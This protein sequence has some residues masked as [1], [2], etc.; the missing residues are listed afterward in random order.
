MKYDL[1]IRSGIHGCGNTLVRLILEYLV[2]KSKVIGTHRYIDNLEEP[3]DLTQYR[4]G[5]I[6]P[7][8]DFRSV[9]AN[10]I[11]KRKMQPTR[12][13]IG[14]VY[15]G[16][17]T[18]MYIEFHKFRTKYPYPKNV[19]LLSYLRFFDNYDY[20]LDRLQSFLDISVSNQQRN[21]IKEKFSMQANKK[22]I[23]ELKLKSWSD[24]D[25]TTLLHGNHIGTGEPDSW[26]TFF[27]PNLHEFITNLMN[28]EL[29]EYGWE[30]ERNKNGLV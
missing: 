24:I 29:V 10:T 19:L 27:K 17:F 8:R 14:Y 20:L 13:G 9:I 2:G 30:K 1:I 12:A 22:R 25:K 16:F 7:C 11:R 21:E 5:I 6:T 23:D 26:K 15:K 28:T 4:I 18:P 3:I